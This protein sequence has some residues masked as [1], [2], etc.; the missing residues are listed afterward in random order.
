M[1]NCKNNYTNF[2]SLKR[3]FVF[4]PLSSKNVC[5]IGLLIA[6]SA[7]LSVMSG[8]LRI[9]NI[10]KLSISFVSVFLAAFLYGGPI[11]A[12]VCAVSDIIS[13]AINP[14][15]AFMPQLT[16]I[17][18]IYGFIYGCLFYK[19][20][21]KYYV[22]NLIICNIFLF[23]VNIFVKTAILSASFAIPYYALLISR[24]PLCLLQTA[25]IFIVLILIKP[26]LKQLKI[27]T[28]IKEDKR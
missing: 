21:T 11:G 23:A 2:W 8:Y 24:L 6:V 22:F 20:N 12:I 25:L 7:V 1:K 17:E 9:G 28:K 19:T 13:F 26:F 10:S 16:L 15:A 27:N 5:T 4:P 14:V 18:F 3:I